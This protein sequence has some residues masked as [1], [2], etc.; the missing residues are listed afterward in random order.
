VSGS[1]VA[2]AVAAIRTGTGVV[3]DD[4][5]RENE[6]DVIFAA[7][8]LTEA[9]VA[10]LM[11]ECRGLICAA[12]ASQL[13][14]ALGLHP[15]V[16]NNEDPLRTAFT[17]SVDAREGVTTGISA[18]DR[19]LTARLLADPASTPRDFVSPGHLFPLRAAPGGVR[20]RRGHTEAA[21]DLAALAGVPEVGVICEIAGADGRMLRGAELETFAALHGLPFISIGMLADALVG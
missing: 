16:P 9:Q 12:M 3:V 21:V 15:M 19:T 10:F 4:A 1:T 17:V 8:M 5:S 2:D 7:A 13:V 6:G 20:S 11:R 18:A 14:D